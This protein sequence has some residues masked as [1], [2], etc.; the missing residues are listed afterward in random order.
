MWRISGKRAVAW[1]GAGLGTG[2]MTPAALAQGP[3]N[4]NEQAD[5]QAILNRDDVRLLP[6]ALRARMADIAGRPHTFLPQPAAAEGGP[7]DTLGSFFLLESTGFQRNPFTFQFPGISDTA[8]RTATGAFGVPTIGAT[9][10]VL[11]LRDS[12]AGDIADPRTEANIF[13]DVA[14][15]IPINNESGWYEG[16]LVHDLRVPVAAALPAGQTAAAFGTITPADAQAL[17]RMGSG[18]NVPGAVFTTN[19][20]APR[21]PAATDR[22]P[23]NQSN[24]VSVYVSTGTFNALQLADAHSFHEFNPGTN[25]SFP[26]YELPTSGGMTGVFGAGRVGAVTSIVPGPGPGGEANSAVEFGDSPH[27]PRDPDRTTATNPD[28]IETRVR[29]LPS[30]L[31]R[32]VLLDTYMR[33]AS[34]APGVAFPERLYRAYEAQVAR[35]DQDNNGV[36]DAEEAAIGETTGGEPNSRLYIPI[37]AFDRVVITREI[38]DGLLG[39]RFGPSQRAWV[40]TG[41]ATAPG[42]QVPATT[43]E[44]PTV[45]R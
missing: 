23:T 7:T 14:G 15:L 22:F 25:W 12:G 6:P 29:A 38:N 36:I 39:P 17:A 31:A 19:G 9:R 35:V 1:M 21:Q 20:N 24:I 3:L 41:P 37:G 34:F 8:R 26:T 10:V 18:N 5:R 4:P 16:W 40:L 43:G 45:P 27:V 32:E 11:T 13:T 28:Q 33:P 44:S 30:G 42:G 2:L